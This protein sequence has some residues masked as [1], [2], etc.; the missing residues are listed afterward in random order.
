VFGSVHGHSKIVANELHTKLAND[1]KDVTI[2]GT[3]TWDLLSAKPAICLVIVATTGAGDLPKNILP[4]YDHLR[5]KEEKYD[6]LSYAVLGLGDRCFR[7][8]F[9]SAGKRMDSLLIELNADPLLPLTTIDAS[10]IPDPME[11]ATPW[12]DKIIS[13]LEH[14]T[15]TLNVA[16]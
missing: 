14:K 12:L 15:D 2:L 8:T 9:C 13:N 7:E 16:S 10:D 1:G 4:F 11:V 3:D 6:D 5:Q